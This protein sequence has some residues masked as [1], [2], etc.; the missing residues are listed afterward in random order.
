MLL[1][2]TNRDI[3][4]IFDLLFTNLVN[5]NLDIQSWISK[6]VDCNQTKEDAFWLGLLL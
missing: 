6:I 4:I 1:K 2:F 3:N 5:D